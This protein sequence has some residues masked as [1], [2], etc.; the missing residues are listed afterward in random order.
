MLPAAYAELEHRARKFIKCLP[1]V[2]ELEAWRIDATADMQLRSELE[3]ALVGRVLADRP[4]NDAMPTRYP[5]G[6][7][8]S[9]PASKGLPG[10]RC[11]G[12]S[13]ETGDEK[14]AGRYRAELQVMGG[15]QFRK[16]LAKMVED[17]QLDPKW[18]SGRGTACV[19]A[20]CLASEPKLCTGLLDALTVVCGSAIDFVR[21]AGEMTALE[22]IDLLE[23]KAGVKRPRAVQLVG[24]SH[25]IRVLGWSATGLDRTNIWRAKK[26]FEAAGVDPVLI[27]FSRVQRIA[28]GAGM[29]VGGAVAG[30][31]A[32]AGAMAGSAL[33]DALLPDEP[34]PKKFVE[35]GPSVAADELEK[36]A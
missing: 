27:D 13:E 3:C 12:K 14:I 36:A 11:Y 10:A 22:A 4:L 5:T 18:L 34:S 20:E 9:W 16:Q 19:K 35:P 7:S 24:Y 1:A 30:G 26:D 17:G 31:L 25:L 8:V 23:L 29:I 2:H 28:A 21:E 6:G 33:V 15:K 32:V